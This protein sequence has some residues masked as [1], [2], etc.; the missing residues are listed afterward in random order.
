MSQKWAPVEVPFRLTGIFCTVAMDPIKFLDLGAMVE[1]RPRYRAIACA[2]WP[3]SK[4]CCGVALSPGSSVLHL[5]MATRRC[6][7]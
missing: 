5:A 6:I 7:M 3:G 1:G 2:G 4:F